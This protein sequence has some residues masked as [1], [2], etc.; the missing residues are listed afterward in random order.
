MRVLKSY[1]LSFALT[2]ISIILGS[3]FVRADES[4]A[5]VLATTFSIPPF[6]YVSQSGNISGVSVDL[7]FAIIESAGLSSELIDYPWKRASKL[8]Q[9]GVRDLV[10]PCAPR[11]ER[12][13][14]FLF[15][16]TID[17]GDIVV[18]TLTGSKLEGKFQSID[19]LK[20]LGSK[21][22]VSDGYATESILLS[23]GIKDFITVSSDT[24]ILPMLFA[25]RFDAFLG[26]RRVLQAYLA[27]DDHDWAGK[28][29]LKTLEEIPYG[30]C[31]SKSKPGSKELV[32]RLNLAIGKLKSE[33]GFQAI[34]KKYEKLPSASSY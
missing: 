21:L 26:Y 10:F 30:I 22:G 15:T 14:Y 18:A 4:S 33:G 11:P 2:A 9:I 34:F 23:L 20:V 19:Q 13:D 16:E 28:V 5:N 1:R 3:S 29:H 8:V 17:S 25:K 32:E 7:Y 27:D 24:S 12:K 6:T 31:V